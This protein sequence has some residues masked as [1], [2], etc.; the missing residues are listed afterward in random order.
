[1][2]TGGFEESQKTSTNRIKNKLKTKIK[3]GSSYCRSY[4]INSIK[5]IKKK[6]K[7]GEKT[8]T[9][10]AQYALVYPCFV[11]QKITK[12]DSLTK[13]YSNPPETKK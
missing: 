4:F 3:E 2:Y 9:S 10:A 11:I 12:G 13:L 1:M 6:K 5:S 8:A 7:K